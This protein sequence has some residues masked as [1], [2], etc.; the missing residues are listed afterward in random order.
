MWSGDDLTIIL[1]IGGLAVAFALGGVSAAGWRN[2]L[3][4]SVLFVISAVLFGAAFSW[5]WLKTLAPEFS[6]IVLSIAISPV[7]WFVGF[8]FAAALMALSARSAVQTPGDR[9]SDSPVWAVI[10]LGLILLLVAVFFNSPLT[11]SSG[12][13]ITQTA[14]I[15][16]S[17][18]LAEGLPH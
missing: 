6:S 9:R 13:A 8:M 14:P 3:L 5:P 7:A 1:F 18:S 12:T 4:I 2:R 17:I 15:P 11:S 10:V 16:A